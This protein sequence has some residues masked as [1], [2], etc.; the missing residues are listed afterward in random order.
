VKIDNKKSKAKQRIRRLR[1]RYKH[2]NLMKG[3]V[4][5]RKEDGNLI[6]KGV[7]RSPLVP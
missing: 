4:E 5:A 6:L 3:L 2:L 1:G 7:T